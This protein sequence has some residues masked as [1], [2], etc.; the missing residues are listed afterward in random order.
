M[1]AFVMVLIES[2]SMG[3]HNICFQEEIEKLTV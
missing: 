2:I 1:E 3:T